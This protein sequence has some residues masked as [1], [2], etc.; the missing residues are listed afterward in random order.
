MATEMKLHRC[1]IR[2]QLSSRDWYLQTR[3]F[4]LVFVCDHHFSVAYGRP[5]LTPRDFDYSTV[6]DAL[7]N[8]DFATEDDA[9]LLSQVEIWSISTKIYY[10]VGIDIDEPIPESSIPQLQRLSIALDTWRADW[11][12]RF[13]TSERVGNYPRKGVRLHYHF[14]KLYLCSHAFRGAYS[15]EST[16][17]NIS[18]ELEEFANLAIHSATAILR[19]IIDDKEFQSFLHGLPAYYDTMMAFAVV[20][21]VKVLAKDSPAVRI[22]RTGTYELMDRLSTTLESITHPMSKHHLLASIASSLR[23]VV[24]KGRQSDTHTP[25][26]GILLPPPAQHVNNGIFDFNPIVDPGEP[27][28]ISNFDFFCPPL[29]PFENNFMD[30][31]NE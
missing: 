28:F 25:N 9:R 31:S 1:V 11:S 8:C 7:L 18:P 23:S 26:S 29:G 27:G 6:S 21:L 12:D 13:T 14:A 19:T 22:D 30:Y 17:Y 15:P 20:F 24:D 3:L 4:C 5:P 16:V 2:P 10:K